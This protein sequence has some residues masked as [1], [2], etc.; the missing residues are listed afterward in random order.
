[1]LPSEL[2]SSSVR[3]AAVRVATVAAIAALLAM[4]GCGRATES[5]T[6]ED[7]DA[8]EA[9]GATSTTV[10]P[11][12]KPESTDASDPAGG[13]SESTRTDPSEAHAS[14]QAAAPDPRE[15]P[16]FAINSPFDEQYESPI[17]KE[18]K[19]LWARPWRWSKAPDLVVEKWLGEEPETEGKYVLIEFWATWCGPCR[20]SIP[21]L[22]RLHEKY[23]QELAVIGVSDET[24]EDVRNMAQNSPDVPE[25]QYYSAVDTQ[26]RMKEEVGVF[27][28]PH[29]MILEP[30]GYVVWEGF[31]LLDGHELT[32]EIVEKILQ[33]GRKLKAGAAAGQ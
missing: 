27:G 26:A 31:P 20:R 18:G 3:C 24:E 16:L 29:A 5:K 19:R 11:E 28:I 8:S 15:I 2:V 7:E 23:G 22:N 30:D 1:M 32:E 9:L 14:K 4:T 13:V 33:V 17:P 21:L 6:P 10:S 12:A 25:I